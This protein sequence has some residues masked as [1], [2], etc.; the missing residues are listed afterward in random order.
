MISCYRANK[1]QTGLSLFRSR[2]IS[3]VASRPSSRLS[4]KTSL[5]LS[6]SI[7]LSAIGRMSGPIKMLT[8]SKSITR[9]LNDGASPSKSLPSWADWKSGLSTAHMKETES[10]FLKDPCSAI[11]SS[12]PTLWKTWTFWTRLSL[13]YTFSAM[14]IC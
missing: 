3:E 14:S 1:S 8:F 6:F 5:N 9:S 2:E 13:R 11:D 4:D 7:N 10:E 12:L